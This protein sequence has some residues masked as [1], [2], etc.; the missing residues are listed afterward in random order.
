MVLY[1][2]AYVV[3]VHR[4]AQYGILVKNCRADAV[5]CLATCEARKMRLEPLWYFTWLPIECVENWLFCRGKHFLQR[6]TNLL[7]HRQT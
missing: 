2:M 7:H 1:N 3:K 4:V 5:M 6:Q